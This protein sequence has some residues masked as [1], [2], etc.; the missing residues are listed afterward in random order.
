MF[1]VGTPSPL[2]LTRDIGATAIRLANGMSPTV[3][4]SSR[5]WVKAM[6]GRLQGGLGRSRSG[7]A[8]DGDEVLGA[9]RQHDEQVDRRAARDSRRHG[10]EDT[11]SD[12]TRPVEL[13]SV[14]SAGAVRLHRLSLVGPRPARGTDRRDRRWPRGPGP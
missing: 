2:V 14:L 6:I 5:G 9:G 7:A 4:G 10:H 1:S 11:T 12:V 8:I 3:T 13:R